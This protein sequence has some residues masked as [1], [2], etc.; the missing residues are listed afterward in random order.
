MVSVSPDSPLGQLLAGPMRPGKLAWIGL[1]P[2]RK[3]PVLTPNSAVLISGRGVQGDHYDTRQNGPRQ[4]TLIAIEDMAAMASFLGME[5][6]A[7]ELLR[8]NFVTNGINLVAL[9]GR[10]FRIGPA[11]LEWSGE[12]APCSRMD[13]NLGPGGF[14]AVRGRGGITARVIEGGDVHIGDLIEHED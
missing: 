12:C 6:I 4:V 13:A 1:R 5:D 2:S 14:N 8:R 11:L 9:K 10:R 7:P 3:L